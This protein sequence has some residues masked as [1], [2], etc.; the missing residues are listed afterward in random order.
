MSLPTEMMPMFLDGILYRF[1]MVV[2][3]P[4]KYEPALANTNDKTPYSTTRTFLFANLNLTVDKK[5]QRR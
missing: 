5:L 1:S 2:I 4:L 3:V